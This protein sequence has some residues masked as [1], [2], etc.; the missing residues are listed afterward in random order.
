MN[1]VICLANLGK[2]AKG[3]RWRLQ[4][5]HRPAYPER[6]YH[7]QALHHGQV[8]TELVVEMS[9]VNVANVTVAMTG[10]LRAMS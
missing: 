9:I 7:R 4:V 6:Q 2:N 3:V 8:I 1:S 5:P 10:R